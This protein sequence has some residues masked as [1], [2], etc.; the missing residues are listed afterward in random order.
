MKNMKSFERNERRNER[1]RERR[2]GGEE[3]REKE[4]GKW[5]DTMSLLCLSFAITKSEVFLFK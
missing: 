5:R 1:E 4:R 2:G 3:E